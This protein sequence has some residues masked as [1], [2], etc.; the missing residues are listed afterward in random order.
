MKKQNRTY[1]NKDLDVLHV[2]VIADV[3]K[4]LANEM[5]KRGLNSQVI[6]RKDKDIFGFGSFEP[7]Q[8][9]YTRLPSSKAFLLRLLYTI[10][11]RKP[12]IVH[13][14]TCYAL[15]KWIKRFYPDIEII[16]HLHGSDIRDRWTKLKDYLLTYSDKIIV[17]TPDLLQG[18]MTE[19][20]VELILN[21]VNT[22]FF[23]NGNPM[24]KINP[25]KALFIR[26]LNKQTLAYDKA[27]LFASKY[28]LDLTI[29]NR[30]NGEIIPYPQFN[31]FLQQFNWYI[32]IKQGY[33][34]ATNYILEDWSVTAKQALAMG[35]VVIRYEEGEFIEYLDKLSFD[36]EGHIIDLEKQNKKILDRWEEIYRGV[37]E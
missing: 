31:N 19:H 33:T 6:M 9:I 30:K 28:D 15:N 25:T 10:R 29:L 32:D 16:T 36:R 17:A 1:R 11:K 13:I 20:D 8:T 3:S 7:D 4:V 5:N 21:P 26:Q 14:H 2:W 24:N 23:P 34:E 35:K 27:K 37:I 22:T 12:K 18:D